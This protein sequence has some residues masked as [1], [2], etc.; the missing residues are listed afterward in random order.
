MCAQEAFANLEKQLNDSLHGAGLPQLLEWSLLDD[1]RLQARLNSA[2]LRLTAR[3]AY[4]AM[5]KV[6]EIGKTEKSFTCIIQ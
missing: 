6:P 4:Q 2:I 1:P 5:A 3:L